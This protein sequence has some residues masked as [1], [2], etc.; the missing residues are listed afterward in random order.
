MKKFTEIRKNCGCGKTPCET[1]GEAVSPAQQ[2]A[3]AI[4]KKERG[5]KPKN[6][7]SHDEI[8]KDINDFLRN[9]DGSKGVLRSTLTEAKKLSKSEQD[10]LNKFTS[11][12]EVIDVMQ[13]MGT[14]RIRGG[15]SPFGARQMKAARD[16]IDKGILVS[17]ASPRPNANTMTNRHLF[18]KYPGWKPRELTSLEISVYKRIKNYEEKGLYKEKGSGH[19]I[20]MKKKARDAHEQLAKMGY[21]TSDEL[22]P[23]ILKPLPK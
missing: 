21:V 11:A 17:V 23:S 4:S 9:N 18:V 16:L 10:L 19:M 14:G 12:D 3:I 2:A 8:M 22:R 5:E 15:G 7:A 13:Y 20:T 1:Y 6:E